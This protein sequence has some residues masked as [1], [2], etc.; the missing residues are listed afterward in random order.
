MKGVWSLSLCFVRRLCRE[1][2]VLFWSLLFPAAMFLMFAFAFARDEDSGAFAPG[3][4]LRL[5]SN[6][7]VVGLVSNGLYSAGLFLGHDRANGVLR[8]LYVSGVGA[9]PVLLATMFRQLALAAGSG[10][11]LVATGD[12]LTGGRLRVALPGLCVAAALGAASYGGIGLLLAAFSPTPESAS[13]LANFVYFP[14]LFLSGALIPLELLPAGLRAFRW[15]LPSTYL[16]ELLYRLQGSPATVPAGWCLAVLGATA[17]A[18]YASAARL[19][20]WE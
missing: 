7:L 15:A 6:F 17:L 1:R 8:R 14:S 4:V 10:L 11:A 19:F 16:R 12:L 5:V 3:V 18:G 20:R 13:V 2:I 9:G